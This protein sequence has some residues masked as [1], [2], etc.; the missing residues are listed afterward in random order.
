MNEKQLKENVVQELRE[1]FYFYPEVKGT[2]FSGKRLA[3]DYVMKPKDTTEWKNK[4]IV[5]GVEF[6][7][8][9]A[10]DKKGDT[11]NFTKWIAQCVD[12]SHTVWDD[13]GYLFI[14]TCPGI[15]TSTF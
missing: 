8:V 2:H 12:Y 5:F 6:K 14:L 15:T 7:D 11:S 1:N 10:L 4:N 3:L 9:P 13:F